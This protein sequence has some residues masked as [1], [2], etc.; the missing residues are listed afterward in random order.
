LLGLAFVTFHILILLGDQFIKYTP[1]QL[2][3]PF[4]SANFQPIW[5]G[6]GQLAFYLLIPLTFS[7]YVRRR[8]GIGLWRAIHFGTFLA[9]AMVTVHGMLAGS[10][11]T[12]GLIYLLYGFTGLSV[13]FLTVYRMLTMALGPAAS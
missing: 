1:A 8:I 9:F 3:I 6:I 7:F 4:G 12:N 5:V 2:L 13:I 10:D 11:T